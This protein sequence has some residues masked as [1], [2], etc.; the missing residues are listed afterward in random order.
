LD[1]EQ[2]MRIFKTKWFKRF[3]RKESIAD[4][5]LCEAIERA[6]SGLIDADLGDGLIKQ[7]VAR[8][9]AGRSGGYRTIIAFRQGERAFFVYGFA[10]SSRAN[11]RPDEL[12]T[13]KQAAA[14]L[15][16]QPDDIIQTML[17]D[18]Q[19]FEVTCDAPNP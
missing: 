7:R 1:G 19:L 3:A 11:L 15:L 9:G 10:K 8:P 18:E 12:D 4:E 17:D 5:Q 13:Y 2:A 16:A 14:L 6:E